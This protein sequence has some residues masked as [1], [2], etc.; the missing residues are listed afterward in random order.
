MSFVEFLV[1]GLD[2]Y[3]AINAWQPERKKSGLKKGPGCEGSKTGE[4]KG[5]GEWMG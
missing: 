5:N 2:A 4:K 1:L 3:K